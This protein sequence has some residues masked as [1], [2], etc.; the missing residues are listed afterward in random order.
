MSTSFIITLSVLALINGYF[1]AV[2]F[3]AWRVEKMQNRETVEHRII[4][5]E[6]LRKKR[7]AF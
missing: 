1:A 6:Q 7:R 2:W 3:K 4:D 5:L